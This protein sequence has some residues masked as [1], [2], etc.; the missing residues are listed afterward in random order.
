M[1]KYKKNLQKDIDI[2]GWIWYY[3]N[4]L[5]KDKHLGKNIYEISNKFL[6][7]E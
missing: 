7:A 3:M 6:N 4:V 5:S 2:I 1:E